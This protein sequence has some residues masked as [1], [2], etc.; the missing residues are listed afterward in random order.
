MAF[1][2]RAESNKNDSQSDDPNVGPGQYEPLQIEY[3]KH[4]E[5]ES[6]QFQSQIPRGK[7]S[8]LD[9]KNDGPSP[10]DYF[11]THTKLF[12]EFVKFSR[13][14]QEARK[15]VYKDLYDAVKLNI[16]P[17]EMIRYFKEHEHPAFNSKT[18]RFKYA[19]AEL[20]EKKRSPSP[21]SY[22]PVIDNSFSSKEKHKQRRNRLHYG[23]FDMTNSDLRIETIPSKSNFGYDI[24]KD[25]IIKMMKD[26]YG[27]N[28]TSGRKNDSVGPADYDIFPKWDKNI[29]AWKKTKD[30]SDPKYE[31]IKEAK[32]QIKLSQL[33][34][35]YIK[36]KVLESEVINQ[37][38][39]T[40]NE[41]YNKSTQQTNTSS[42]NNLEL[43][44]SQVY[45]QTSN[46]NNSIKS[47]YNNT[48][49]SQRSLSTCSNKSFDRFAVLKYILNL[50]DKTASRIRNKKENNREILFET[51]PGP[52]YYT[53]DE[54]N[55]RPSKMIKE[56]NNFNSNSKRFG[57][58]FNGSTGE[59]VGP[60]Y[61][62]KKTTPQNKP[63][64]KIIKGKIPN[65]NKELENECGLNLC[66]KK[67]EGPEPGPQ[68]Y[69]L[70]KD[71]I[72][73]SM[74]SNYKNF[75]SNVERFDF[76]RP[77][78]L[79][80]EIMSQCKIDNQNKIKVKPT[81]NN[82]YKKLYL[83]TNS[84]DDIK[85]MD[86]KNL[87]GKNKTDVYEV[88]GVGSYNPAIINTIDYQIHSR[89]NHFVNP[90]K[91]GFGAQ[92]KKFSSAGQV[93]LSS[94]L[95]PGRYFKTNRNTDF[96]GNAVVTQNNAP[97][98]GN[99]R[100]FKYKTEKETVGPGSYELASFEDWNKKSHN[101]LFA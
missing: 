13:R 57:N 77:V 99:D 44:N 37:S 78:N 27:E 22:D 9:T 63:G 18:N 4:P 52:G 1:V 54:L 98:N 8:Y 33:E 71:I 81:D 64:G 16:I 50:R 41:S 92:E 39:S 26:P 62:Y 35:D 42:K 58:S 31:K 36:S 28:K 51:E 76:N 48:Q 56:V 72:S 94:L 96:D 69:E 95:G 45:N 15:F 24:D 7:N 32:A 40:N 6:Y 100:R 73:K 2:F 30:E 86:A 23:G 84:K 74:S 47:E 25:G 19:I 17:R 89:I 65:L 38:K 79:K 14:K 21:C 12:E 85:I 97:F 55:F 53:N 91:V 68:S 101:I 66:M 59:N 83:F 43:C 10:A 80:E 5:K 93:K 67:Y 3:V 90:K 11:K 88:P 75:G 60:G 46:N 87:K 34:E 82:L 61:Y 29:V 70:S 20:E 49:A